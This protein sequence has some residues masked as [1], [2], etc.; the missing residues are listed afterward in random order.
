MSE[1]T[2]IDFPKWKRNN[3]PPITKL[4]ELLNYAERHPEDV[5]ELILI[6]ENEEGMR[7]AEADSA[8]LV[9]KMVYMLEQAKFDLLREM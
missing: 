2:V 1:K 4:R 9:S 3:A 7:C 8:M 6:W 5:K